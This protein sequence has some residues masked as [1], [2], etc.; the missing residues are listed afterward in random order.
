MIASCRLR[1][2]EELLQ[3]L[4]WRDRLL[5]LVKSHLVLFLFPA[6]KCVG[7]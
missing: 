1:G 4:A 7:V 2:F 3:I 5:N 6:K